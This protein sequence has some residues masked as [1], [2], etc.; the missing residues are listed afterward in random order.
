V[1]AFGKGFFRASSVQFVRDGAHVD[2]AFVVVTDRE[3]RFTSPALVAGRT[4]GLRVR[5]T[6]DE[7][8]TLD[9][10]FTYDAAPPTASHILTE[11][12]DRL[13]TESGDA[14]ITES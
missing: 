11:S 9:N 14:L 8:V 5:T 10:A 3:L 6:T 13:L 4:Y 1:S 7:D 2:I 12:G